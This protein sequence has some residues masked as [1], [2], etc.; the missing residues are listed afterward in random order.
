MNQ[1]YRKA[2]ILLLIP[3][4]VLTM[5]LKACDKTYREVLKAEDGVS[6][7]IGSGTNIVTDLYQR[8]ILDRDEKNTVAGVLLDANGL[9]TTFNGK[10]KAIHAAGDSKAA[11]LAAADGLAS[12][13]RELTSKG[14]LHIKNPEAKAKVDALFASIESAIGILKI[15]V[16][17]GQ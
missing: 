5:G 9:L 16:Q 6:Q 1:R 15:A 2:S 17:G 10:V 12:G 13:V 4:L 7:A 14:T 3:I 11:Y 8:Q